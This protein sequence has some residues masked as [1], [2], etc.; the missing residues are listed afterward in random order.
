LTFITD[1]KFSEKFSDTGLKPHLRVFVLTD[2]RYLASSAWS[3][4]RLCNLIQEK[5][6]MLRAF[7]ENFDIL[8]LFA[9]NIWKAVDSGL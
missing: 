3:A 4:L 5:V 1:S 7:L 6:R 8:L 2:N 9:Y